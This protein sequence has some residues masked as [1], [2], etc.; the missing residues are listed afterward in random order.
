MSLIY[1]LTG[2]QSNQIITIFQTLKSTRNMTHLISTSPGR[3]GLCPSRQ[4]Y[5]C[6]LLEEVC[7]KIV[8]SPMSM[9]GLFERT[10]T[11]VGS[12]SFCRKEKCVL[13]LIKKM[14]SY[15]AKN[16]PLYALSVFLWHTLDENRVLEVLNNLKIP[17]FHYEVY[18][19]ITHFATGFIRE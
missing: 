4:T 7:R 6:N 18:K 8:E 11:L 16:T 3:P 13:L 15:N 5:P 14:T 9:K 2:C 12:L 10:G 17:H 19:G 1:I